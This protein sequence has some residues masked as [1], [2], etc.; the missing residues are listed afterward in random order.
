MQGTSGLDSDKVT[1]LRI[2]G[3]QY[4]YKPVSFTL[5]K[6]TFSHTGYNLHTNFKMSENDRFLFL[7]DPDTL[8]C[9]QVS[10]KPLPTGY[11]QG[12]YEGEWRLLKKSNSRSEERY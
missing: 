4:D 1:G 10:L 2:E 3:V 12:K 11:T 5:Q 9:D 8:V 7:T 6:I